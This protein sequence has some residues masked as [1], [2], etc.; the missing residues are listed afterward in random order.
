M[1]PIAESWEASIEYDLCD[2]QELDPEFDL[3]RLLRGD[4]KTRG[5]FNQKMF[6]VGAYS[7]NDIIRREGG[8]PVEGGDQRFI[9]VNM[10]PLKP[11]M[12]SPG[13]NN[14]GAPDDQPETDE[15]G[16]PLEPTNDAPGPKGRAPTPKPATLPRLLALAQSAVDRIV[17]KEVEA[18]RKVLKAGQGAESVYAKHPDFVA[19]ALGIAPDLATKYCARQIAIISCRAP[20]DSAED[21]VRCIESFARAELTQLAMCG[22]NKV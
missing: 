18:L 19:A 2:D 3:Q 15:T 21:L 16:E 8:N 9:P 11:N 7:T 14:Q 4:Q 13:D 20:E 12:P 5:D 1:T 17:R 6:G 10:M 22:E